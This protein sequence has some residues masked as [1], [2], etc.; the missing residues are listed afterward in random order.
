[1]NWSSNSH[2]PNFNP[3][4]LAYNHSSSKIYNNIPRREDTE[5]SLTEIYV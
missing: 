1:M 3:Q 2:Q 5:E 4:K